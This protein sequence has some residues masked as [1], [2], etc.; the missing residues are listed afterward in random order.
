MALKMTTNGAYG[1][2]ITDSYIRIDEIRGDKSRLN[3]VVNVYNVVDSVKHR[4]RE[5]LP[6]EGGYALAPSVAT[7]A[8]NFIKQG[9]LYLK[10][11]DE[12][13]TATDV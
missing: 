12:F 6:E 11:L 13:S 1:D 7:G 9:Y 3:L 5:I 8:K 10:T 4:V 2:S